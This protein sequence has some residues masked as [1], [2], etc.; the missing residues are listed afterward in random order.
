MLWI[1]C[2]KKNQTT[3]KALREIENILRNEFIGLIWSS[4]NKTCLT[5]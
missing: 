5:D 3:N 4:A 1:K 2:K